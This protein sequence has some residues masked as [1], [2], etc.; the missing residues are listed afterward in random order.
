MHIT[1]YQ[2]T[3]KKKGSF[4]ALAT[5]IH[6]TESAAAVA[7]SYLRYAYDGQLP[8]R[9]VFGVLY[10]DAKRRVTGLEVI[11][12]GSLRSVVVEP[13]ETFK[14]AILASADAI[15]IFHNHPSG[16]SDPSQEDLDITIRLSR[17]GNLLGIKLLDSLILGDTYTSLKEKEY[18]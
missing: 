8:D 12:I 14:G 15:I 4:P 10:L 13:R 16:H 3:L 1:E 7:D 6:S 2:V 11:S 18:F 17:A 5:S 9:E